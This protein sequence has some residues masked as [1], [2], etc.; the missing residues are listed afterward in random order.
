MNPAYSSRQNQSSFISVLA[1][2]YI[3]FSGIS[4]LGA[5]IFRNYQTPSLNQMG[6]GNTGTQHFQNLFGFLLN[7]SQILFAA[8]SFSILLA[9]IALLRRKNW[10]RI[11]FIC[12]MGL[13]VAWCIITLFIQYNFLSSYAQSNL[14]PILMAFSVIPS[15]GFASLFIWLI[16]QLISAEIKREFINVPGKD[17]FPASSNKRTNPQFGI[18]LETLR[19]RDM[20]KAI[21]WAVFLAICLMTYAEIYLTDGLSWRYISTSIWAILSALFFWRSKVVRYRNLWLSFTSTVLITTLLALTL[22]NIGFSNFSL[23]QSDANHFAAIYAVLFY[24]AVIGFFASG[25]RSK[26]APLIVLPLLW[27]QLVSDTIAALQGTNWH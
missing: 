14:F 20:K 3:V 12:L 18:A 9:A 1:W 5:I 24:G 15:L 10:G 26:W 25:I 16:S 23:S 8:F 17:S 6:I 13:S 22:N 2:I 4:L 11:I 27:V 19:L 7:H 21:H